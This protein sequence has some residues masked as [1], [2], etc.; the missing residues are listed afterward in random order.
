MSL[1]VE[2]RVPHYFD[3]RG[4][5]RAYSAEQLEAKRQEQFEQMHAQ[6]VQEIA[7]LKDQGHWQ[8]LSSL[9]RAELEK[10]PQSPSEISN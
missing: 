2:E 7:A 5:L 3:K 6:R 10:L 8:Q 9:Q 4:I 1:P